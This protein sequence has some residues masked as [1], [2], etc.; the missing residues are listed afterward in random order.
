M[1]CCYVNNEFT[2][3]QIRGFGLFC[4]KC[5]MYI[6]KDTGHTD[7]EC[8]VAQIHELNEQFTVS[9]ST[10]ICVVNTRAISKLELKNK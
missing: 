2:I 4:P 6:A 3:A 9:E 8:L 1:Y 10:G 7:D 5:H